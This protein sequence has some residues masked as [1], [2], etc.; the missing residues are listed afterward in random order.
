[1]KFGQNLVRVMTNISDIILAQCWELETS[2][3]PF[4]ILLKWQY[5]EI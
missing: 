5:N 4:M 3:R 1:M 2:S